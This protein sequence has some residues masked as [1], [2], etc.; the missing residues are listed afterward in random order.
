MIT[1]TES[2]KEQVKLLI[3]QEGYTQDYFLR[4]GVRGG[5]CAGFFLYFGIR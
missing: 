2:A 5:G 1:I 4:V 3:K